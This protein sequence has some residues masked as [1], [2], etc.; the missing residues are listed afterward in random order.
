MNTRKVV[1]LLIIDGWG[2]GKKDY[3]NPIHTAQPTNINT[4]KARYLT[5]A[6]QS[7]GIAVG[8]PWG[9]EGNSEV[10][11][12]TLGAGKVIY[13]H[14]PR[15]SLSIRDG[16]FFKNSALHNAFAHAAQN[17]S[18][19]HAMGLLT[20]GNIHASMEHIEGLIDLASREKCQSF[21]L[22][23]FSDGKDSPPHSVLE[24]LEK[25]TEMTKR[26]GTGTLS[27]ISGRFYAEDRDEHWDRTEK[28]YQAMIGRAPLKIPSEAVKEAYGKGLDDPYI[29]PFM[30]GP[31][32]HPVRS[33]DA[34]I[35]FD[36]REDS[37]RQIA[38]TFIAPTFDKFS[39]EPIK[40]LY[41]TTMTNYLEEFQVPVAYPTETIEEPLG[42]VLEKNNKIQI[43][44]AETEKYAHVTYFFNGYREQPFKNEYRVL[45]PSRN[46]THIDQFPEMMT[47]EISARVI[48]SIAS[49]GFDSIVANFA[50]SDM[51][52]HT[53]NY[54]AGVESVRI[55]DEE[56]GKIVKTTL[57]HD[58]VLAITSDHGHIEIMLDPLTGEPTTRHAANLVPFYLV[59][60]GFE[61]PKGDTEIE[62]IEKEASG[63]LSDV[64]PTILELMNIPQ[65]KSM[66]GQ[67]LLKFLR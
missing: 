27:T 12:L 53:G 59:G 61:R 55:I 13:Q 35:F 26:F 32:P 23:L 2:I 46:V 17:Q 44:I 9:E 52:A 16:S 1:A 42:R 24:L 39:R 57:D 5:G 18:A 3:S 37:I 54:D 33:N 19:V 8:L 30:V 66:T 29:E 25:I 47:K 36:F 22:H 67:S 50:S 11:H 4:L 40:N 7:S 15:I 45:I 51:V 10:G 56:I 41:V 49:G 21:F 38:R 63:L 6:L 20:K 60:R 14:Y 34:L 31:E 43:R 62:W 58:A 28:A 48:E 65:P 64:A